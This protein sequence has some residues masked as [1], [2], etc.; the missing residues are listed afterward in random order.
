MD[1]H[2]QLEPLLT[3]IEND[4]RELGLWDIAPPSQEALDSQLPFSHDTL[5]FYQWL[6]WILLPRTRMLVRNRANLPTQSDIHPM[7]ELYFDTRNMKARELLLA[8]KSFDR[9]L[10]R[11]Q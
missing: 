6:Q 11:Q 5:E 8:L 2:Q 1:I 9:S 10:S 3:Q 7:A 4:L